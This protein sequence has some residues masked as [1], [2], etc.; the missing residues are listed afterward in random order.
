MTGREILT[1]RETCSRPRSGISP[2][3]EHGNT[4]VLELYSAE[5]IESLLIAVGHVA[6][7]IP[8]SEFGRGGANF[9]VKGSVECGG[10]GFDGGGRW[11]KGA[12]A[13]GEEGGEECELHHGG[14]YL[15]D[16]IVI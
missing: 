15:D 3:G 7:R 12:S 16:S 5:V 4:S 8:A 2:S 14:F 6:Q 10:F 9:I 11:G 1:A 13:A